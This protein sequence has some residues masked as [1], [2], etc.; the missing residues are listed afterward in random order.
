MNISGAEKHALLD[1]FLGWRKP[2]LLWASVYQMPFLY[3]H[4]KKA[5]LP[6]LGGS[7]WG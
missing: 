4:N 2:V 3:S 1:I 6:N 7:E 5:P